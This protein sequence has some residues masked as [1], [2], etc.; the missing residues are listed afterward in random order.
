M[1]NIISWISPFVTDQVSK[2]LVYLVD[3]LVTVIYTDIAEL[4]KNSNSSTGGHLDSILLP[5]SF[6]MQKGGDGTPMYYN[7]K[8]QKKMISL[9]NRDYIRRGDR[10]LYITDKGND[11]IKNWVRTKPYNQ[12]LTNIFKVYSQQQENK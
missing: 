9:I 4:I 6:K 5:K 11:Y 10:F 3:K 12:L 2:L 7:E 8:L 1:N